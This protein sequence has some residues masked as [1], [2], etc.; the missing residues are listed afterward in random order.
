MKTFVIII[1]ALL[2]VFAAVVCAII[3]PGSSGVLASIR[4]ADGSEY[5]VTQRCN[6][7]AEPYT[8]DFYVRPSGGRWGWCYIDHEANRWRDVAM[9]YDANTDVITITERG[10]WQAALDRK[11]GMFA[12]GDGKQ[13]RELSSPQEFRDPEFRF[14]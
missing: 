1:G 13:K 2:L 4:L 12:I 6:W 7:S 11:R 3:Q 8:V 10:I 5:M 14:P 9:T